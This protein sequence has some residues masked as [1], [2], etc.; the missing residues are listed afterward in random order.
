LVR[1]GKVII[2]AK[3]FGVCDFSR[4]ADGLTLAALALAVFGAYD[5]YPKI[6]SYFAR[7]RKWAVMSNQKIC[8][9]EGFGINAQNYHIF[10][11]CATMMSNGP[12][13]VCSRFLTVL[14]SRCSSWGC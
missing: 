14:V 9:W 5:S 6:P 10:E 1:L 3:T 4:L 2:A 8:S 13:N 12:Q 7:Y 11:G